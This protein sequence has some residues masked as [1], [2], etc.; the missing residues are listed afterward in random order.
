MNNI[1]IQQIQTEEL[2]ILAEVISILDKHDIKAYLAGGSLIGY[3]RHN[4]FI[5][6]DDDIDIMMLRKDYIRA[7]T[8]LQNELSPQYIY[9][10][11]KGEHDYPY[12]FAKVRKKDSAFVHGG[13]EHLNINQGIYIDIF[14]LDYAFED[15]RSQIK[16]CKKIVGLRHIVDLCFMN[17]RKYGKIRSFWQLPIIFLAHIAFN[18]KR[19]QNKI[20]SLINKWNSRST[21][22]KIVSYCSAYANEVHNTNVLGKGKRVS[23]C[24]VDILIPENYDEYLKNL[25]GD[26]MQ[27]P[28]KE[29]RVSHHDVIY[30]SLN[31]QYNKN[32]GN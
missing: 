27:L 16:A 28:P 8:I 2:K 23:F 5:P 7:K 21:K 31:K 6:W 3:V 29:K 13:D 18:P 24:G 14:P 30:L 11:Y 9:C 10:D 17:Y 19:I 26:Y 20:D 22:T 32:K 12:N 1:S 4:G 15:S 25:Y